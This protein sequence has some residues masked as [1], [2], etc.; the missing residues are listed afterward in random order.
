MW[1]GA[2]LT[3]LALVALFWKFGTTF[4]QAILG[5]DIVAD[6]VVTGLF[7]WLFA[8]TGT[9]SGMMIAIASGLLV[10][11]LLLVGKKLGTSRTLRIKREG[12]RIHT[13]WCIHRGLI[14][15][16]AKGAQ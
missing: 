11:V 4:R 8:T 16:L 6:I 9:I 2:F 3:I 5:Y 13:E 7:V 1:F 10:S 12:L 15:N 14:Y